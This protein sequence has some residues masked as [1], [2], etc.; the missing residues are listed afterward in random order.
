M[1]DT[2]E[3]QVS[4]LA[5]PALR[6]AV[7]VAAGYYVFEHADSYMY[8]APGARMN[9]PF[10]LWRPDEDWQQ[11]GPLIDDRIEILERHDG[12]DTGEKWLAL[13]SEPTDDKWAKGEGP[14][15]SAC[16]AIVAAHSGDTARVPRELL[17]GD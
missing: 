16:R 7:A 9:M 6:Y 11:T 5:G 8:R 17:E 15:V 3:V 2:V 4:E 10:F 1:T 13:A 12:D 14:L